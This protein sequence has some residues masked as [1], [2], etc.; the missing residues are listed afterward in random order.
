M[1]YKTIIIGGGLMGSAAAW[2]LAKEGEKVLLLEQQSSVY[3]GGS[4]LGEA[5]IARNL[6]PEGDIWAFLHRKSIEQTQ[7]LLDF[8][9]ETATTPHL[10]TDIYRTS[11]VSYIFYGEKPKLG[12]FETVLDKRLDFCKYATTEEEAELYFNA[13]L[14]QNASALIREYRLHSGTMNPQELIRKLHLAIQQKQSE[15]WYDSKVLKI[16]KKGNFYELKIAQK[17]KEAII[18]KAEKIITAA[19]PYTGALLADIAPYF[20]QLIK[21]QR[22]FLAFFKPSSEAYNQ[23]TTNQ[24]QALLDAY[25]A[26]YFTSELS[27]A[28]VE[29]IDEDGIPVIKIGGHFCRS[30]IE[31]MDTVWQQ[32]LAETEIQWAKENTLQ[33]LHDCK[34]PIKSE[35]LIFHRGY[36]CVYS[37]T[38]SE[39]PL[40]TN[41]LDENKQ[42]NPNMVVMGGMSGVGA[43]GAMAYGLMAANLLLQKEVVETALYHGVVKALG[44]ERLR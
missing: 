20:Q 9:N 28:M 36:S 17:G 14:P 33:H 13:H 4:S 42:P 12:G 27:F 2:H 5:R 7:I 15:I 26:I 19:G 41:I 6:G 38:D 16:E 25:P 35:S 39:I 34:I 10:M 11:P 43:K 3:T 37:L 18:L 31:K 44:V 8:L 21:P 1:T 29:K 24:Q 22:V 40:V 23:L 32:P 30:K